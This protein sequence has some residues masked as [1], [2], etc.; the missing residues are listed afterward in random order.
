LIFTVV[1]PAILP[2][3][4]LAISLQAL[5]TRNPNADAI[6]LE[7]DPPVDTRPGDP[8]T[9][10]WLHVGPITRLLPSRPLP[11]RTASD[12]EHENLGSEDQAQRVYFWSP[13]LEEDAEISTTICSRWPGARLYTLLDEPKLFRA[14]AAAPG[15][16]RWRPRLPEDRWTVARCS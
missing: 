2:A 16:D 6:F 3:S 8:I 12:L 5:G 7:H 10:R 11:T 13:A 14:L 9:V 1:T 4:S 15:G